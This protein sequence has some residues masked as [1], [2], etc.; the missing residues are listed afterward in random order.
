MVGVAVQ[1][2]DDQGQ[3]QRDRKLDVDRDIGLA[4]PRQQHHHGADAGEYQHEGGGER[5][6]H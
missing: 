3:Q 5:G 2:Q 1:R 6:Q 4:E